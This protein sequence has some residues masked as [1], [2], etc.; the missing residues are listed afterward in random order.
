V[1]ASPL[2]DDSAI[3]RAAIATG[4]SVVTRRPVVRVDPKLLTPAMFKK[5]PDYAAIR[6]LLT[7][8]HTVAGAELTTE[9]VY[10]LARPD[11][12]EEPGL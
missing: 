3:L 6:R 12:P 10:V 1:T 2:E 5:T 9:V 7:D 8:G 4:Y 11:A